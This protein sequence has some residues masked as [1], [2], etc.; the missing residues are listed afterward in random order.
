MLPEGEQRVPVD[1][2][3]A[4][5][6]CPTVPFLPSPTGTHRG[7]RV[8]LPLSYTAKHHHCAGL[9]VLAPNGRQ[10]L[11]SSLPECE[12][13]TSSSKVCSAVL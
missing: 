10:Q 6:T 4:L 2:P 7:C 5:P 12:A 13:L 9:R 8:T 11:F 3:T 1:S